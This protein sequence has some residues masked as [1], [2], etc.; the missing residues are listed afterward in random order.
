M[1]FKVKEPSD[2]NLKK[3][4]AIENKRIGRKENFGDEIIFPLHQYLS[5]SKS[6]MIVETEDYS[7]LAKWVADYTSVF[8]YEIIPIMPW[9]KTKKY[10]L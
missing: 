4:L 9:S 10:Y 7:K 5:E 8:D 6:F 3:G 2:E 1:I